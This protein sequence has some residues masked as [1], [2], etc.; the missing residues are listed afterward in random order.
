VRFPLLRIMES[1]RTDI[2]G[3]VKACLEF[4]RS[5]GV[6]YLLP[7]A[8][9]AASPDLV[10]PGSAAGLETLREELGDCRRCPLH[11]G[12]RHLVFG[13]GA[14]RARLMFVGEGPG[15]EEDLQGRPFVG[16]A[17]ALL[18]KMIEAM[19]L[20]RDQVY[21][22]NVVKCRPPGN[23]DPESSEIATCVPF[24]FAQIR[25]VSPSCLV[26]L[27]KVATH[28]LLHTREPIT[29]IRGRFREWEGIPV[30]PTYHP[31]FLLRNE[32]DRKW[33]KEAWSDLQLVM[34]ALR[35]GA[36]GAGRE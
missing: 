8:G 11:A 24:L 2:L 10:V 26:S 3:Q 17:G 21:I 13:E 35:I 29:R 30:M 23:R 36:A 18:T 33:K 6:D 1:P 19:G 32:D 14:D 5:A 15:A 22:A 12:R 27:G 9:P 16:R 20:S 25:V 28:A 34:G 4:I 31:S 7:D